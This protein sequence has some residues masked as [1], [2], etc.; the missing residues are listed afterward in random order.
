MLK[1]AKLIW[2]KVERPKQVGKEGIFISSQKTPYE[3]IKMEKNQEGLD[4]HVLNMAVQY[5][6]FIFVRKG[7]V[8]KSI[9]G[10]LR[11]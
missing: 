1:S 5:T 8:G 2:P 4:H 9:F 10:Y 6:R 11:S 7:L 3:V